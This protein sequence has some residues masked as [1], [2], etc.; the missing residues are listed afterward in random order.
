MDSELGTFITLRRVDFHGYEGRSTDPR[1][2]VA[3]K[4]D[5]ADNMRFPGHQV[6]LLE[7]IDQ[8]EDQRLPSTSPG[9][10]STSSNT[11]SPTSST[12]SFVA[13]LA[14]PCSWPMDNKLA[15][16]SRKEE[17]LSARERALHVRELFVEQI[18]EYLRDQE[19]ELAER[20]AAIT[21]RE[22][23]LH[24]LPAKLWY[25][26]GKEPEALEKMAEEDSME[27]WDGC[28]EFKRV[29]KVEEGFEEYQIVDNDRRKR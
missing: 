3:G 22:Q 7:V 19:A 1:A 23:R 10:K 20:K 25:M 9:A 21:A 12:S 13:Q 18:K 11:S 28:E 2:D 14:P 16:P 26:L 15:K 29:E 24:H 6:K 5:V 4:G 17:E 8:I 27:D